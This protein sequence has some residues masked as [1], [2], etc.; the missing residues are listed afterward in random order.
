MPHLNPL[1]VDAMRASQ[2]RTAQIFQVIFYVLGHAVCEPSTPP[3]VICA[4]PNHP[5][6]KQYGEVCS[7]DEHNICCPYLG[8]SA[9]E[10]GDNLCVP[11]CHPCNAGDSSCTCV[12]EPCPFTPA[13]GACNEPTAPPI[14]PSPSP[15]R[16]V[17]VSCISMSALYM[18]CCQSSFLRLLC[19]LSASCLLDRS[20]NV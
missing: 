11:Y 14:S 4:D 20:P 5:C 16:L 9:L 1:Q 7:L 8:N 12:Y 18:Y 15:V 6:N 19:S 17:R 2:V 10:C 3:E 13:N